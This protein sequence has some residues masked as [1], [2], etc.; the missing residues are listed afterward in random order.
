MVV[1]GPV[2]AGLE[3]LDHPG[4]HDVLEHIGMISGVK[5]VAVVHAPI[6]ARPVSNSTGGRIY[7]CYEI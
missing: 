7:L 6:Y 4:E 2:P 3:A 5:G 1:K